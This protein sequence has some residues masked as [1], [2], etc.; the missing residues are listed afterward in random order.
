MIKEPF[1]KEPLKPIIENAS[2]KDV[3]EILAIQ[4]QKVIT[5]EKEIENKKIEEEGFLVYPISAEDLG[6]LFENKEK[7]IVKVARTENKIVG[8]IICYD[9]EEWKLAHTD[10]LSSLD[11]ADEDKA[12]LKSKKILYGRHIAVDVAGA[13]VGAGLLDVT[14]QEAV[15]RGYECFVVEILKEPIENKRSTGFVQKEGFRQVGQLT[16]KNNRVWSLF[17]KDLT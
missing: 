3:E 9:L 14:F 17:V 7:H 16:D 6:K 15:S 8:Y 12:F 13:S 2:Q 4:S 1:E 10:W 5:P 11:V